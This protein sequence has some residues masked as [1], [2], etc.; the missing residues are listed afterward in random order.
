MSKKN[1]KLKKLLAE[2]VPD[3]TPIGI[4]L[5]TAYWNLVK[6]EMRLAP[7]D[8]MV[9]LKAYVADE[10]FVGRSTAEPK[11]RESRLINALT[12]GSVRGV[13]VDFTWVRFIESLVMLRIETLTL[14]AKAT[15]G[16]FGAGKVVHASCNPKQELL[17]IVDGEMDEDL[18]GSASQTLNAFFKDRQ[19]TASQVMEHILLKVLWSFFV[20]YNIDSEMWRKLSTAYVNNPKNCPALS[21]RRNDKRHNLQSAIR[22]TKKISW[23]KFLE[24]LKAI[25]VREF[26]CAFLCTN[27]KN[28]SFETEIVV[29]LTQL[30]FWSNRNESE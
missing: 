6:H 9:L 25:D 13:S 29:D 16:K 18:K 21:N 19:R 30:V 10:R 14:T 8:W 20:E 7:V 22:Y 1:S 24:A 27:D 5:R 28:Q 12:G 15:R 17:R 23:K 4:Y 11:E 3:D 26:R 2:G